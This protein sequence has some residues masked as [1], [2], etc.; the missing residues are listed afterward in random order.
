MCIGGRRVAFF[1]VMTMQ[2]PELVSR[3]RDQIAA[4]ERIFAP[5]PEH[6]A[7]DPGASCPREA[8]LRERENAVGWIE[9]T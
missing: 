2:N 1:V 7:P 4:M 3:G 9:T 8:D 5:R 6:T